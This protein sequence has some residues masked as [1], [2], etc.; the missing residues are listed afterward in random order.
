M[1]SKTTI[2]MQV[3]HFDGLFKQIRQLEDGGKKAVRNT[4]NDMNARAPSWV[5]A[6]VTQKY[7]ISKKE[8][9]PGSVRKG[10][11]GEKLAV[12]QAGKIRITGETI[13]SFQ[14]VYKGRRLTPVHFGMTPKIPPPGKSYTLRMQVIK[15]QKKVI[16]RYLNTR[17]PGGP[18]SERSHNILMGTGAA[19]SEGVSH[20]PFQRM[21]K[22]RTDLHKFTAISVPQMVDSE[23]VNEKIIERLNTEAAKRFQHNLDRILSR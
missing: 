9:I 16:G 1:M 10:K 19:T 20:I 17:T 21:S 12:K 13:E 18:Y 6:A 11:N 14:M 15:G 8:I 22:T 4:V 3:E 5:A 7:N 2:T 23:E